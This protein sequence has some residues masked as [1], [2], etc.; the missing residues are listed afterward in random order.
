[1]RG[2]RAALVC[3]V[4]AA[5]AGYATAGSANSVVECPK[6][7]VHRAD[8][9]AHPGWV[10]YSNEPLRLSGADFMYI[11]DSHLEATLDPDEVR[12][13][14]DESQTEVSVFRVTKHRREGPFTLLCEYG[15]HAQLI[16]SIPKQVK[17]CTVVRRK[18]FGEE[19]AVEVKCL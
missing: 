3:F 6:V 2:T 14:N 5:L 1:M 16:R 9:G 17:E 13:L 15:D 4:S 19:G 10:I 18:S 7:M 12:R 8:A 11:V